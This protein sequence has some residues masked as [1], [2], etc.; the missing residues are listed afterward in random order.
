MSDRAAARVKDRV[1]WPPRYVEV[2]A[3]R[4]QTIAAWRTDAALNDSDPSKKFLIVGSLEYYR[5]RPVEFIQDW[6][7]TYDPRNVGSDRPTKMPFVLFRRQVELV[8]FLHACVMGQ[9]DGL[10]EKCRDLGATWVCCAFS[11]WLWLFWPGVAIGW[12]SRK[13]PLVDNIG[14][15]DSIF[16]KIRM[17]IRRLPR[18]LLPVGFNPDNH[19]TFMRVVNPANEATI[20][21]EVGDNIGRGGRKFVYFK[22]ES[23]HYV[24][25]ESIES[26]LTDNTRCQIDVSSVSGL[27]TVFQK[28]RE[29]GVDWVPGADVKKGYTN[30]FVMA[31]ED[32]PDKDQAWYDAR[33]RKATAEGLLHIFAQEVDRDYAAA[34]QG[35]IIEIEWVRAAVNAHVKLELG[36]A[37]KWGAALDVADGGRDTNALAMRKGIVLRSCDEWGERDTGATARRA[38]AACDDKGSIELQYDAIGVGSGVK[39]EANRLSDEQLMPRGI[40]MVPWMAG[41]SVIDPSSHVI[42]DDAESPLNEDLFGNLKAQGW[43]QLARR[44][45]RT[46]RAINE[47]DF[48]WEADDL[49]SIDPDLPLLRKLEKELCQVTA[50]QGARLKMIVEKAPD[51]TKSPNLADA[52]MMAY[53]PVQEFVPPTPLFGTYGQR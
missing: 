25:P 47:P 31:W 29:T 1:A 2:Y 28:K 21:G 44:F 49:I 22:D 46:W 40:K 5:T 51:G 48:T 6:C 18:E 32:H 10:I 33:K 53:W 45:E 30:V 39:S 43:W 52:V 24:H 13:E 36:T 37:G 3:W 7:E 35:T 12:G 14:D 19:M 9:A 38:I 27:N 4:S 23:A 34:V 17:L 11:V 50:K 8:N 20:T 16:E 41:D 42:P 15:P 26:A